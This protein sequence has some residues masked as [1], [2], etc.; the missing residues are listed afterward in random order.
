MATDLASPTY[1]LAR[2]SRR[3]RLLAALWI[4][5]LVHASPAAA[6]CSDMAERLFGVQLGGA[7]TYLSRQ[8]SGL[9][10]SPV[11]QDG[12][13]AGID[14]LSGTSHKIE[15]LQ[16]SVSW[17]KERAVSILATARGRT[18]LALDEALQTISKL[19]SLQFAH[20]ARSD[21]Y[22]LPCG[23]GLS[24]QASKTQIVRGG[25]IADIPVLTLLI[26]HPLK[27]EM[28]KEVKGR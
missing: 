27:A 22:R 21:L 9:S 7:R 13:L 2:S 28:V 26:D 4:P 1:D 5:V 12:S 6:D 8:P 10:L 17:H 11:R 15:F 23:D 20:D 16:I 25:G 18:P 19:A 14:R 3:A 24:V